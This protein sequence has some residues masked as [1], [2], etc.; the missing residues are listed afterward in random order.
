MTRILDSPN[1]SVFFC[2]SAQYAAIPKISFQLLLTA[3][4]TLAFFSVDASIV[5]LTARR[6]QKE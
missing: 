1:S 2:L 4:K 5:I 3:Y 6:R